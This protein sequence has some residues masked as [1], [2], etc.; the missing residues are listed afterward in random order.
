MNQGPASSL[1]GAQG[2]KAPFPL[3]LFNGVTAT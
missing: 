1:R 3:S 2:P